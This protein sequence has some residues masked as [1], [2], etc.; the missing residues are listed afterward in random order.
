MCLGTSIHYIQGRDGDLHLRLGLK[1]H[2][3]RTYSDLR[4]DLR[5]DLK[6]IQACL[7]LEVWDS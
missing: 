4:L 3:R 6:K 1:L 5:L 7:G 2:L